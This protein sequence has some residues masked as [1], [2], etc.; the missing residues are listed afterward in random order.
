MAFNKLSVNGDDGIDNEDNDDAVLRKIGK[1]RAMFSTT[2]SNQ[3]SGCNWTYLSRTSGVGTQ[4]YIFLEIPG[5]CIN[6]LILRT[7]EIQ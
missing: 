6:K 7:T 2:G 5:D 3:C 4:K 1:G